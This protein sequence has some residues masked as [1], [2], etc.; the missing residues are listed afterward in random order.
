MPAKV[1][2]V[3]FKATQ[4]GIQ[5]SGSGDYSAPKL[6]TIT[7][8]GLSSAPEQVSVNGEQVKVQASGHSLMF[9]VSIDLRHSAEIK[10]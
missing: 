7:V 9:E 10:F 8:L 3:T 6:T 4:A 2:E 5:I 1:T